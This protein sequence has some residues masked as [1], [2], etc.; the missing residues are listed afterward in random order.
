MLN[1]EE[2]LSLE[3]TVDLVIKLKS[4]K[5]TLME[6]WADGSFTGQSA[7]NTL[8]INAKM[9][10]MCQAIDSIVEYIEEGDVDETSWAQTTH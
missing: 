9:I 6:L 2:W 5:E 1:R 4:D 7:D 3:Q 10:G 8:Q